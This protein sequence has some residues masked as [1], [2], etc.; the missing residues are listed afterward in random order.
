MPKVERYV[1]TLAKR[2][3]RKP[4]DSTLRL[5][6]LKPIV[7]KDIPG[8]RLKPV[9]TTRA[10]VLALKTQKRDTL[11]LPFQ[12]IKPSVESSELSHAIVIKRAS[13]E[14]LFYK[15]GA[16]TKLIRTFKVATGRSEYPTPLGRFEVINKQANPWWY[17]PASDWAKDS[18]P[19]P[20]GPSNPLGTRWMGISAPYVGIHGTP[21]AASIGYSASHGCVRMLIPQVEWLFT[22][23][24]LGTP[25]FIVGT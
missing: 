11:D 13:N 2:F 24:E 12:M 18:Q 4:V 19:I 25:V 20:P 22:K 8:R 23:V 21:N 10:I 3:E 7:A 9:V 1:T 14:L 15:V 5:R 17:P 16:K 6:N